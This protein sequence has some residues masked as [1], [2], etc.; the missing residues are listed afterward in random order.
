M[1]HQTLVFASTLVLAGC[2]NKDATKPGT[3]VLAWVAGE[4]T[5]VTD[6][7]VGPPA[8]ATTAKDMR[9]KVRPNSGWGPAVY[10]VHIETAELPTKSTPSDKSEVAPTMAAPVK[11]TAQVVA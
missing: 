1:R 8:G 9:I 11:I 7:S 10:Q 3:E 6:I 5:S 2:G 4:K